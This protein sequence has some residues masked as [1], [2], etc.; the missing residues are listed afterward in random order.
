MTQFLLLYHIHTPTRT[1]EG[2]TDVVVAV[3]TT[4]T[5]VVKTDVM[6]AVVTTAVKIDVVIV[7]VEIVDKA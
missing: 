5:M 3:V 1:L 6:A 7:V 2:T 4:D